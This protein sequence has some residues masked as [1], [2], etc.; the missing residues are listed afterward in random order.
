MVKIFSIVSSLIF[1]HFGYFLAEILIKLDLTKKITIR[2]DDK[3]ITTITLMYF[4]VVAWFVIIW[5]VLLLSFFL[6][7]K[8]A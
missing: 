5:G 1:L 8:S 4:F 3:E 7:G 2:I 6:F